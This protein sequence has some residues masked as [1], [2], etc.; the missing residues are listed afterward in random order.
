M[1]EDIDAAIQ[2]A[3][4]KLR[5]AQHRVSQLIG[6]KEQGWAQLLVSAA[7]YQLAGLRYCQPAVSVSHWGMFERGAA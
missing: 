3:E 7:E 4:E 5:Q 1:T 6:T 2:V